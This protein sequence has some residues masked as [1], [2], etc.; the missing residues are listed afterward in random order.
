MLNTE[1]SQKDCAITSCPPLPEMCNSELDLRR[2]SCVIV[3]LRWPCGGHTGEQLVLDS[4]ASCRFLSMHLS[5]PSLGQ[6]CHPLAC[7]QHSVG[8]WEVPVAVLKCSSV[9]I[10]QFLGAQIL[11]VVRCVW[12]QDEAVEQ[13]LGGWTFAKTYC[14]EIYS[15]VGG[16]T[17]KP[18]LL[19]F[20]GIRRA[21]V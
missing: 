10:W 2:G 12:Q 11:A 5:E 19:S 1:L 7:L 15:S 14:W 8:S 9:S 4:M 20:G 21:S 16:A 18:G 3:C 6:K 13:W 17:E